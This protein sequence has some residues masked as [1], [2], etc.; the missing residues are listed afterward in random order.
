MNE[1][2]YEIRPYNDALW[3]VA[4]L[5]KTEAGVISCLV[6]KGSKENCQQY[7]DNLN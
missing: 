7:V 3:Y 4:E 2:T 6:F 5:T 1:T